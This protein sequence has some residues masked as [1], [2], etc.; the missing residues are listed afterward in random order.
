LNTSKKIVNWNQNPKAM[1]YSEQKLGTAIELCDKIHKLPNNILQSC[2]IYGSVISQKAI[3]ES[4][5][6]IMIL[7]DYLDMNFLHQVKTIC[8]QIQNSS[9]QHIALSYK[10]VSHFLIEMVQGHQMYISI[11][12]SGRCLLDSSVFLGIQKILSANKL[13][14]KKLIIAKRKKYIYG[15]THHFFGRTMIDFVA[16]LDAIVRAYIHYKELEGTEI[17]SWQ[18]YESLIDHKNLMPLIR[19]HLFDYSEALQSFYTIKN[20]FHPLTK[21]Q[22]DDISSI[23]LHTL[24]TCIYFI[25]KEND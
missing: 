25:Q 17:S 11:A 22:L 16:E 12:L 8:H 24:L 14:Q 5:I 23:E 15:M 13:P 20:K 21:P 7:L 9:K 19:K 18:S 4:D 2:I 3:K 10:T 6:D 1:N